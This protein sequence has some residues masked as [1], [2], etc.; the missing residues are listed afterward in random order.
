[1]NV[2]KLIKNAVNEWMEDVQ[3]ILYEKPINSYEELNRL[4]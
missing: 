1:M 4:V 3:S 2:F